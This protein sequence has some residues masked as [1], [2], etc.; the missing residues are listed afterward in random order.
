MTA[1]YN[2]EARA[3]LREAYSRFSIPNTDVVTIRFVVGLPNPD[4]GMMRI[5]QWE[6]ERFHDIQIL[7]Q[8]ENMNE[9]KTFEYFSD[10]ARMYPS[11]DSSKR[12]WDYA[13]KADDDTFI[14]LPNLVERLRFLTPRHDSYIVHILIEFR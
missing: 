9:G 7:D 12:P 2:F 5:L 8:F 6:Q 14:N 11:D 4:P 13:M 3:I 1:W 10:L